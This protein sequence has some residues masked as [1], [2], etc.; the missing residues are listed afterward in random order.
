MRHNRELLHFGFRDFIHL[1]VACGIIT[2]NS[3]AGILPALWDNPQHRIA[4]HFGA[5]YLRS[6]QINE[7]FDVINT[8]LDSLHGVPEGNVPGEL[9]LG[10]S[11]GA[12]YDYLPIEYLS[13]APTI[14]VLY[15]ARHIRDYTFDIFGENYSF[16][17]AAAIRLYDIS[18]GLRFLLHKQIL[19]A[20][21]TL[22]G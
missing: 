19:G 13:V 7:F 17:D 20:S 15:S 1:A 5:L 9:F 12:R 21:R 11:S 22:M 18:S 8:R 10:F 16:T 4:I 2:G 3:N 6:R 14:Q